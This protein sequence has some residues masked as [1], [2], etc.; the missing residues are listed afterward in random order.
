MKLILL[1]MCLFVVTGCGAQITHSKNPHAHIP[2]YF[3]TH[4]I[5]NSVV[6]DLATYSGSVYTTT[7]KRCVPSSV[8]FEGGLRVRLSGC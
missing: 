1:A 3:R 8:K 2:K 7:H 4:L 6:V 5:D